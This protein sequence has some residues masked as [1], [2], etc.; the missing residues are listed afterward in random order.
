MV[1]AASS[2]EYG[3]PKVGPWLGLAKYGQTLA[4]AFGSGLTIPVTSGKGCGTPPKA[5]TAGSISGF[6]ST[7]LAALHARIDSAPTETWTNHAP[8]SRRVVTLLVIN[9]DIG[10]STVI[11]TGFALVFLD[12]VQGGNG[13][14][15]LWI[16]FLS[17]SI[18]ATGATIDYSINN[19]T[20]GQSTP[21]VIGFIR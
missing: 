15:G 12:K 17:G 4:D 16:H 3:P 21:K 8:D 6:D 7:V 9:G 13:S 20:A 18:V 11:P 2:L 19:A 5:C 10:N 14:S 1:A